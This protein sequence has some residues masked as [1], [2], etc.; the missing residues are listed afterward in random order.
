[1]NELQEI[2]KEKVRQFLNDKIMSD[3]VKQV[4]LAVFLNREYTKVSSDVYV[5]AASRL[6]VDFLFEGFK[7]LEEYRK[8]EQRVKE[9]LVNPGL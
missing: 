6:A 9:K 1:M 2:Q 7:K 5:M 3:A 4:F 8:V